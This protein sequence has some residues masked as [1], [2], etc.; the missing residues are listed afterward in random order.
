[1]ANNRCLYC[2]EEIKW[3]KDQNGKTISVEDC[4]DEG[5]TVFDEE[6]MKRHYCQ[7]IGEKKAQLPPMRD[8]K[9]V[10]K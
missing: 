3:V 6:Q 2:D 5:A 10:E 1:M 4:F 9:R 8:K 7:I